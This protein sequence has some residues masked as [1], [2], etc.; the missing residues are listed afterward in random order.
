MQES[1]T[2]RVGGRTS[3]FGGSPDGRVTRSIRS[4]TASVPISLT[5]WRTVVRRGLEAFA[6][7]T[8]SVAT[9]EIWVGQDRPASTIARMTPISMT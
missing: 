1:R 8:S 5:G 7:V 4:R 2:I 9:M 3:R 6:H